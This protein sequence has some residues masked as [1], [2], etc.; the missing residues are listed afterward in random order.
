MAGPNKPL[1]KPEPYLKGRTWIVPRSRVVLDMMEEHGTKDPNDAERWSNLLQRDPAYESD[2]AP[3][4]RE[5]NEYTAEDFSDLLTTE[6]KAYG[7]RGDRSYLEEQR[8]QDQSNIGRLMSGVGRFIPGTLIKTAQGINTSASWLYD[9]YNYYLGSGEDTKTRFT[10]TS[11]QALDDAQKA[12]N[13]FFPVF[14]RQSYKDSGLLGTLTSSEFWAED[15]NEG[16]QF[17]ASMGLTGNVLT[18]VLGA[19][20]LGTT[21]AAVLPAIAEA[22]VESKGTYEAIKASLPGEKNPRTGKE[23]TGEEIEQLATEAANRVFNANVALH[24]VTNGIQLFTLSNSAFTK[25]IDRIRKDIVAGKTS[26]ETIKAGRSALANGSL[27]AISEGFGEENIQ[28]SISMF[29]EDLAKEGISEF[30]GTGYFNKWLDGVVGFGK[31]A[32]GQDISQDQKEQMKAILAGSLIGGAPGAVSGYKEAGKQKVLYE[33]LNEDFKRFVKDHDIAGKNFFGDRNSVYKQFETEVDELDS[34]GKPTGKKVIK[35]GIINPITNEPEIDLD[36]ARKMW[37]QT[38]WDKKVFDRQIALTMDGDSRLGTFNKHIALAGLAY[39]YDKLY[40]SD[41]WSKVGEKA[42]EERLNKEPNQELTEDERKELTQ[43]KSQV[44]SYQDLW[45]TINSKY[46]SKDELSTDKEVAGFA[47]H[48]KDVM[49]YEHVKLR[50]YEDMK[51]NQNLSKKDLES[52][53]TMIE[54]TQNFIEKLENE[55]SSF[56]EFYTQQLNPVLGQVEK[57]QALQSQIDKSEDPQRTVELMNEKL[58]EEFILGETQYINSEF[59]TATT[60]TARQDASK[61]KFGSRDNVLYEMGMSYKTE[62]D[63]KERVEDLQSLKETLDKSKAENGYDQQ[64]EDDYSKKQADLLNFFSSKKGVVNEETAN[65]VQQVIEEINSDNK[66]LSEQI[67]ELKNNYQNSINEIAR[68]EETSDVDKGAADRINDTL[69]SLYDTLAP[70]ADQNEE[71]SR[72]LELNSDATQRNKQDMLSALAQAI[73]DNGETNPDELENALDSAIDRAGGEYIQDSLDKKFEYLSQLL[74]QEA[75]IDPETNRQIQVEVAKQN[76]LDQEIQSKEKQLQ[77]KQALTKD[78]INRAYTNLDKG[79]NNRDNIIRDKVSSR[80]HKNNSYGRIDHSLR[81]EYTENYLDQVDAQQQAYEADK[82]FYNELDTLNKLKSTLLSAEAV[83]VSRAEVVWSSPENNSIVKSI[84][85]A[86][87]KLDQLIAVSKEN[88]GTREKMLKEFETKEADQLLDSIGLNPDSSVK[89]DLMF[90]MILEV[91]PNATEIID[92]AKSNI[93]KSAAVRVVIDLFKMNSSDVQKERIKEKL[94][95]DRKVK[96]AQIEKE[97]SIQEVLSSQAYYTTPVGLF[98]DV[99][100]AKAI[101]ILKVKYTG[102]K[103]GK[104]PLFIFAET[105]DLNELE[106]NISNSKEL[107]NSDKD[108][109][110]T[111]IRLH[112]EYLSIFNTVT[113]F[114]S[115]DLFYKNH[116]QETKILNELSDKKIFEVPTSEQL[117]I[118]RTLLRF[119]KIPVSGQDRGSLSSMWSF[120]AGPAGAGKT[121]IV[122]SWLSKLYGVPK[123]KIYAFSHNDSTS[124]GIADSINGKKGSASE[125]M[126]TLELDKFDLI[127]IDELPFFMNP[128]IKEF[129]QRVFEHNKTRKDNPL[130]VVALGDPGQIRK[131]RGATISTH[132]VLTNMNYSDPLVLTFRSN[133]PSIVNLMNQFRRRTSIVSGLKVQSNVIFGTKFDTKEPTIG[134]HAGKVKDELIAALNANKDSGRSKVIVVN[135]QEDKLK[136]TSAVEKTPVLTYDEVQGMTFDE[137]Y[138]DLQRTGK[139]LRG[140][141]F[142]NKKNDLEFNTAMYTAVSRARNYVFVLDPTMENLF[143]DKALAVD[144][145]KL[146]EQSR[147]N[148]EK[149]GHRLDTE[150][151]LI[152]K[153]IKEYKPEDIKKEKPKDEKHLDTG[154]NIEIEE[155]PDGEITPELGV[156]PVETIGVK[157]SDTD[158]DSDLMTQEEEIRDIKEEA[159]GD[160]VKG[161]IITP[162]IL[163]DT[164]IDKDGNFFYKILYPTN[165]QLKKNPKTK[166]PDVLPQGVTLSN[167]VITDSSP[168]VMAVTYDGSIL[169]LGQVQQNGVFT[170]RWKQLG[171]ISEKDKESTFYQKFARDNEYKAT[172]NGD[173]IRY[174][175]DTGELMNISPVY[176]SNGRYVSNGGNNAFILSGTIIESNPVTYTFKEEPT[177]KGFINEVLDKFRKGFNVKGVKYS[178]KIYD[179]KTLADD[180][181]VQASGFRPKPGVPYL[182]ISNPKGDGQVETRTQFIRLTP[183]KLNKGDISEN[184]FLHPLRKLYEAVRELGTQIY[185]DNP[186][187]VL[188]NTVVNSLIMKMANAK[189]NKG[190]RAFQLNEDG[191]VILNR[192]IY[193][194]KDYLDGVSKGY[195]EFVGEGADKISEEQFDKIKLAAEKIIPLYYGKRYKKVELTFDTIEEATQYAESIKDSGKILFKAK[196]DEDSKHPDNLY[197]VKHVKQSKNDK[198]VFDVEM[199]LAAGAGEAQKVMNQLAQ[200]NTQFKFRKIVTKDKKKI[201]T[202]KSIMSTSLSKEAYRNS[203]AKILEDVYKDKQTKNGEA[204]DQKVINKLRGGSL[205][206]LENY[207]QKRGIDR[208]S[209]DVLM[210]EEAIHPITLADLETVVGDTAFKDNEHRF[211]EG[212]YLAL[213]LGMISVNYHGANLDKQESVDKIESMMGS[214]LDEVKGGTVVIGKI[215]DTISTKKEIVEEKPLQETSFRSSEREITE[216]DN[217]IERLTN[218]INEVNSTEDEGELSNK[219]SQYE[220]ELNE[221]RD[222]DTITYNEILELQN[223]GKNKEALDQLLNSIKNL[224][225]NEVVVD[226]E[227]EVIQESE[228]TQE[229]FVYDDNKYFIKDNKFYREDSLLD[230]IE[231]IT[232]EEYNAAKID[233]DRRYFTVE[234]TQDLGKELTIDEA[235]KVAKKILPKLKIGN[236]SWLKA[237]L[238]SF[239]NIP[240]SNEVELKFLDKLE[241]EAISGRKDSLGI[242]IDGTIYLLKDNKG[243]IREGVLRHELMHKVYWE[244]LT[245][246]D[247]SAIRRSARRSDPSTEKMS[248]VEFEEWLSNRFMSYKDN[249][250]NEQGRIKQFFSNIYRLLK[251]I[252]GNVTEINDLFNLVDKG[253][254]RKNMADFSRSI[255]RNY[256]DIKNNFESAAIFKES[257]FAVQSHFSSLLDINPKDPNKKVYTYNE[258]YH[259]TKDSMLNLKNRKE[260]DLVKYNEAL[261]KAITDNDADKQQKILAAIEKLEKD[262]VVFRTLFDGKSNKNYDIVTLYL[263]PDGFT[264]QHYSSIKRKISEEDINDIIELD[265]ETLSDDLEIVNLNDVIAESK[266]I[267][268]EAKQSSAVKLLLSN[269]KDPATGEWIIPRVAFAKCLKFM[270]SISFEVEVIKDKT[271]AIRKVGFLQRFKESIAKSAGL[272]SKAD[273]SGAGAIY[274]VYKKIKE[275]YESALMPEYNDYNGTTFT[276]KRRL[277]KGIFFLNP[278]VL[279]VARDFTEDVDYKGLTY[280]QLNAKVVQ[281]KVFVFHRKDAEQLLI[282]NSLEADKKKVNVSTEKVVEAFEAIIRSKIN[283]GLIKGFP[284]NANNLARISMIREAWRSEQSKNAL[285]EFYSLFSSMMEDHMMLAK[286][287]VFENRTTYIRAGANSN[288]L[289]VKS[290]IEQGIISKITLIAEGLKG[291]YQK[292]YKAFIGGTPGKGHMTWSEIES[293]LS[294]TSSSDAVQGIKDFLNFIG[295]VIN[296]NELSLKDPFKTAE[297]IKFFVEEHMSTVGTF[298]PAPINSIPKEEKD[299]LS[300]DEI[301]E[302]SVQQEITIYDVIEEQGSL[303]GRL[304][305]DISSSTRWVRPN[306]VKDSSKNTVFLFHNSTQANDTLIAVAKVF[307]E[308]FKGGGGTLRNVK[309]PEYLKHKIYTKGNIFA[310]GINHI[311]DTY[312]HDGTIDVV[313]DKA[314]SYM[315]ESKSKFFS[316]VLNASM[317]FMINGSREG[318]P[319]YIQWVYTISNKPRITGAGV[320]FLS[321]KQIKEALGTYLIKVS[322]RPDLSNLIKNHK[323][324][325]NTNFEILDT[326][327][328]GNS[329]MADAISK[330][331]INETLTKYGEELVNE[332]YDELTKLSREFAEELA[333]DQFKF[334]A[335]FMKAHKKLKAEGKLDSNIPG[336]LKVDHKDE[337]KNFDASR[338]YNH[339]VDEIHGTVDMMFKNM[340]VNSYFLV[341]LLAGD[342]SFFSN[343]LDL[344]KRMSGVFA[345]GMKGLVHPELGMKKKYRTACISDI[346]EGKDSIAESVS[347]MLLNKPYTELNSDQLKEVDK[348]LALFGSSYKPTDGQAFMLPEMAAEI[349]KGFGRAFKAGHIFKAAHYENATKKITDPD[350]NEIEVLIPVMDK[351]SIVNLSDDLCNRFPLLGNLRRN[352]RMNGKGQEP[353]YLVTFASA[354][355]VGGPVKPTDSKQLLQD[356]GT[357]TKDSIIELSFENLRMQSNPDH[358]TFDSEKGVANPSQLGYMILLQQHLL[359]EGDR[360]AKVIHE[361]TAKLIEKGLGKFKRRITDEDGK[362]SLTKLSKYIFEAMSGKGNERYQELLGEG[363]SFQAPYIVNKALT[364]IAADV[365]KSSVGFRLPGEKL[366]LQTDFGI[367]VNKKNK[368]LR[369]KLKFNQSEDKGHLEAEVIFPEGVLPREVE[370][371]I[372]E[373]LKTGKRFFTTS[374]MLGFRIPSTELHSA[375][376]IKIA[377]FYDSRGTNAIIAPKELVVLHGSDFDVDSLFMLVRSFYKPEEAE[378]FG[379]E[380][381]SPIGYEL[382]NKEYHPI[383]KDKFE[384]IISELKEQY[385]EDKKKLKLIDKVEDKYY[386]NVITQG[387]IDM[388]LKPENRSRMVEPISMEIF[389][390]DGEDTMFT[391]LKDLQQRR[392][393]HIHGDKATKEGIEEAG[394][395]QQRP[396]LSNPSG[397]YKVFKSSMDGAALVGVFANGFKSLAYML[398]SGDYGNNTVAVKKEL[399]KL[400]E[401]KK[402]QE[403]LLSNVNEE[404]RKLDP[405]TNPESVKQ[406][407]KKRDELLSILKE[408]ERTIEELTAK[409]KTSKDEKSTTPFL[410]VPAIKLGGKIFDR[411]REFEVGKDGWPVW[412]TLDALVNSAIDNVKEQILPTINASGLTSNAYVALIGLGVPLRTTVL[413][414]RQ[415]AI[416]QMSSTGFKTSEINKKKE[417]LEEMFKAISQEDLEL[418]PIYAQQEQ[419]TDLDLEDA[420]IKDLIDFRAY[421]NGD[422]DKAFKD[423]I[424]PEH[425]IVRQYAILLEVEKAMNIGEDISTMSSALNIIRQFPSN[426]ADMSTTQEKWEEMFDFKEDEVKMRDSFSFDIPA[427]FNN[428]PHIKLAYEAFKYLVDSIET[429]FLKHDKALTKL[430]T[431]IVKTS[432][433]SIGTKNETIETVK[434]D[435]VK[436]IASGIPLMEKINLRLTKEYRTAT[437]V[438][439]YTTGAEA[440]SQAF[441]D[442]LEDVKLFLKAHNISNGFIENIAIRPG[443][444]DTRYAQFTAGNNLKLEDFLLFQEDFVKLNRVNI[445]DKG[446]ITYSYTPNVGYTEFQQD[447]VRYAI[448]NFGLQFGST[449]YST[450]LPPDIVKPYMD[451]LDAELKEALTKLDV[452]KELFEVQ[453]VI[454]RGNNVGETR[455]KPTRVEVAQGTWRSAAYDKAYGIYYNLRFDLKGKDTMGDFLKFGKNVF[456]KIKIAVES[457]EQ[458]NFPVFYTKIGTL[459]RRI[460]LFFRKELAEKYSTALAFDSSI[461][462]RAVADPDNT[463]KVSIS[464]NYYNDIKT[465]DEHGTGSIIMLYPTNDGAR[466]YRKYYMV[467]KK[468]TDPKVNEYGINEMEFEITPLENKDYEQYI[469]SKGEDY[470]LVKKVSKVELNYKGTKSSITTADRNKFLSLENVLKDIQVNGSTAG[471]L[472]ANLFLSP[473]FSS[474]VKGLTVRTINVKETDKGNVIGHWVNNYPKEISIAVQ[475]PDGTRV[476]PEIIESTIIHE[477]THALT[478]FNLHT[479]DN[480]LSR[481][482]VRAKANLHKLFK[483]AS[484]AMKKKY[485]DE[486]KA[487]AGKFYGFTNI[488]E[489]VAETFSNPEFQAEL[490]SFKIDTGKKYS[491]LTKFVE[492]FKRLLGVVENDSLLSQVLNNSFYLID[493][494][495]N[496]GSV[497]IDTNE[498]FYKIGNSKPAEVSG[499]TKN[500]LEQSKYIN[501]ATD[502]NGE[503]LDHYIYSITNKAWNR[504]TD[505]YTGFISKFVSTTPKEKGLTSSQLKAEGVFKGVPKGTAIPIDGIKK[506]LT[507]EEYIQYLDDLNAVGIAKGKVMHKWLE[508]LSWNKYSNKSK[509]DLEDELE[510]ALENAPV[511][512]AETSYGWIEQVYDKLL[513]KLQLNSHKDNVPEDQKDKIFSE[514][515]I[516]SPLLKYA[517]TMDMLVEHSDGSYSII[518]WK[519]GRSIEKETHDVLM[520]YGNQFNHMFADPKTKNQLQVMFYAF[521]MKVENPDAIFRNLDIMWIPNKYEALAYDPYNKANHANFLRMIEQY[522]KSEEPRIYEQILEK[523]PNAFNPK[524][525]NATDPTLAGRMLAENKTAEQVIIATQNELKW[526]IQAKL[527]KRLLTH[528]DMQEIKKLT[529]ELVAFAKQEGYNIQNWSDDI[530][531]GSRW[532]GINADV[533]HP[534]VN[535]YQARL[536]EGLDKA[537]SEFTRDMAKFNRLVK[538]ISEDYVA[539]KMPGKGFLR[540]ATL[541][542]YDPLTN[543]LYEPFYT[544]FTEDGVTLERFLHKNEKDPEKKKAYEALT[545][546]QKEFIDFVN[547]RFASPFKGDS[548]FL[549]RTAVK[550]KPNMVGGI[551]MGVKNYSDLELFNLNKDLR[552]KFNYYEGFIPV[553]APTNQDLK[554][555][556]KG[557]PMEYIRNLLNKYLT[558]STEYDYE[559]WGNRDEA[560][561]IKYLGTRSLRSNKVYSRN[562]ENMFDKYMRSMYHKKYL[563]DVHA[564]A[565]G[566][567]YTIQMASYKGEASRINK[568]LDEHISM[569][570]YHKGEE[571]FDLTSNPTLSPFTVTDKRNP[572]R[573][574]VKKIS[575]LKLLQAA[576]SS[577]GAVFMWVKP[578]KAA[579]NAAIAS[580][581]TIKEGLMGD[582]IKMGLKEKVIG[583]NASVVDFTTKDL[584]KASG[585][586][587]SFIGEQVKGNYHNNKLWRL[588]QEFRFDSNAYDLATNSRYLETLKTQLLSPDVAYMLHT[589]PEEYISKVTMVAQMLNMKFTT[590]EMNGKSMW[591]AYEMK[592]NPITGESELTYIG[593]TRGYLKVGDKLEK[594]GGITSKEAASMRHVYTRIQGGYRPGERTS[595]EFYA[596]GQAIIQFKK[597]LP[598]LLKTNFGTLS[599]SNVLGRYK[600]V[601]G[602]DGKIVTVKDEKGN[603]ITVLEWQQRITEGRWITLAG[604]IGEWLRLNSLVKGTRLGS[605]LLNNESYAWDN[606]SPEQKKNILEAGAVL[607]SLMSF[608]LLYGWAFGE[609]EEKNSLKRM[610]AYIL[611]TYSQ[612]YNPVDMVK[613]ITSFP[614]SA[615]G[616]RLY[617]TLDAGNDMAWSLWAS[618][619]YSPFNA[620]DDAWTTEGDLKG[621]NEIQRGIRGLSSYYE[622]KKWLDDLDL[623]DSE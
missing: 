85:E 369:E 284:E 543:E 228:L 297:D 444:F 87:D 190:E 408:T 574:Y 394:E 233:K 23:F 205:K 365:T 475:Y 165:S 541:K 221:L 361:Y 280:D 492:F 158:P 198:D 556:F 335:R 483:V 458:S 263:F 370:D 46:T 35:K 485:K 538:K 5:G 479:P 138:V 457:D 155:D 302:L 507:K 245:A 184:G 387:F 405:S 526:K 260:K 131:D 581:F 153:Y 31:A 423:V 575:P 583:T 191:K 442:K 338:K 419:L 378:L 113:L 295:I 229:E 75:T 547:E 411:I 333:Y 486:F 3:T 550:D 68:I 546:N 189:D 603:D 344:V 560:L 521:M 567:Q 493:N 219:F 610:G 593:P 140:E 604:F 388:I 162:P 432:N 19:G 359:A 325:K 272:D 343:A 182:V 7:F 225:E 576:R 1:P 512:D 346:V 393:K 355:K 515:T 250:F 395:V 403:T 124:Q 416:E 119:L 286:Y 214:K 306:S 170:N 177:H 347:M 89:D 254:Y 311:H 34:E 568:Y 559:Q 203:L 446:N 591:D 261:Q 530:S 579:Q 143:P 246:R 314:T 268:N 320:D 144:T 112:K 618:T 180:T 613:N 438:K 358:I 383:A 554:E 364:Q 315:R 125:F 21:G 407:E 243:G 17:L 232:E 15:M 253:Y 92:A 304:A 43:M 487:G 120:L 252:T 247:R 429:M 114:N 326:V 52:L 72:I 136:Y 491:L 474:A 533:N 121:R 544:T 318:N 45:K 13:E 208:A 288:S 98:R 48:F 255:R 102:E 159:K 8:A 200:A 230:S 127:V 553:V 582:F 276:Q 103:E 241:F 262:L 168:V 132:S 508:L 49:F 501:V 585:I 281:G 275:Y 417:A 79:V 586:V 498:I 116:E 367:E 6:Q 139:D 607:S 269:I 532:F 598:Q 123:E 517:G 617:K 59:N 461:L 91:V 440:W 516:G 226:L 377:G 375:V 50:A 449:N 237:K 465:K 274:L 398:N 187:K 154:D 38:V 179:R 510:E 462:S 557:R 414:M 62:L 64:L 186:N 118:I 392:Y 385:K 467:T 285:A 80:L 300:D 428:N 572:N 83:W 224:R 236:Q 12:V 484:E 563:D 329:N 9:S 500:V 519:T 108:Q 308:R 322:L 404:L 569:E 106:K 74:E 149:L 109:I 73:Q 141:V 60:S 336:T 351:Y 466:M 531:Y 363:V 619:G 4:M 271:G 299:A 577:A 88:A 412:R 522:Y 24:S 601:P 110:N 2:V 415:P 161:T 477:L 172:K 321:P 192:H 90:S 384:K 331:V 459:K 455:K 390:G 620:P 592:V 248:T 402:V 296:A 596:I 481:D 174:N 622:T 350:G 529:L 130:R 552:D 513:D 339:T 204:I 10:G 37:Y 133:V 54:D 66:L 222:I 197:Y 409:S 292:A 542:K 148:F 193:T 456:K 63:I 571:P 499:I 480:K 99:L 100:M 472:M 621:W 115:S 16:V 548:A 434:S 25:N 61:L 441:L 389:N 448:L 609:E 380:A 570:L 207:I 420:F 33:T 28:T 600:P 379:Y 445:D 277:P 437:G 211:V 328:G 545:K 490:D 606:L 223:Q 549:N 215:G 210:N 256:V 82:S 65:L 217:S 540:K 212:G 122:L 447:F 476:S 290:D 317:A 565:K 294:S 84:E 36:V 126:T 44:K 69:D 234:D 278:D 78:S 535:L 22:G 349:E 588:S 614:S 55:R 357:F 42:L 323:K 96:V 410:N 117:P 348:I 249:Q 368:A 151:Q 56:K 167:G 146:S 107:N 406:R 157:Q 313:N 298:K 354:R 309:L 156:D 558:F 178:I 104:N 488:D 356:N 11:T 430:A 303:I 77:A 239:L 301:A 227:P 47:K 93:E 451:E 594:I 435:F 235:V 391:M 128:Q 111:L 612:N 18:K 469:D 426:K 497:V 505:N 464:D 194:Y 605:Y 413:L 41:G 502:S 293:K 345:P 150:R 181:E 602:N 258:A 562:I 57:I 518:D 396:D 265:S 360:T 340:Y 374:D 327:L 202:S 555:R 27:A 454:E 145:N 152:S 523:S 257:V 509:E 463:T 608:W 504:V 51:T 176:D 244:Y 460:G 220:K 188:G 305:T 525:Y 70:I 206:Y 94:E 397:N 418:L 366:I 611:D 185:P 362:L 81:I 371:S 528:D 561:P 147:D 282:K 163:D 169:V 514:V 324:Y 524:H 266:H 534:I 175:E 53:D 599:Y 71:V 238:F 584:I 231:E 443:R 427:L 489:F 196:I 316:R 279:I 259:A 589:L 551:E 105:A 240:I 171:V 287:D 332:M 471:K 450:S 578:H 352:M 382:V 503:Q 597:H 307:K 341:D 400:K 436:F 26:A 616:T 29:E 134:V 201:A 289:S 495:I 590:K 337:V 373:M 273:I 422:M 520:K 319:R 470:K 199:Y 421:D 164:V 283:Q 20:K 267:D 101:E 173:Y 482:Q 623:E 353:I 330:A 135:T 566:L 67:N 424:D 473:E 453:E 399:K 142:S 312:E 216:Y 496:K 595:F 386:T 40:T 433:M 468:L 376:A 129:E 539:S 291:D 573:K 14:Q 270:E 160:N 431:E 137:V 452:Y 536:N 95:N 183:R 494:P 242:Y 166:V 264:K 587:A 580:M 310:K 39:Q 478:W 76:T 381:S 372:K 439:D 511:P 564:L 97:L 251:F 537:N 195:K 425:S 401:A 527:D 342:A 218:N 213:P 32:L 30:D 58:N 615:A 209:L 334:D 86:L 506:D